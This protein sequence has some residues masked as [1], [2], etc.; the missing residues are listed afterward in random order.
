MRAIPAVVQHIFRSCADRCPLE[1]QRG[2]GHFHRVGAP[3]GTGDVDG[4]GADYGLRSACDV[5]HAVRG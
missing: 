5:G 3:E 1:I 4:T 2:F